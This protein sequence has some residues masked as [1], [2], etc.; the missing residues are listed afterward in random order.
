MEKG[1]KYVQMALEMGAEDAKV[2][3]IDDI[4][5]DPRPLLK[6]MYGCSDWGKRWTCPSSAKGL[7]P[8]E[9]ERI[10]K[11]YNWGILI[12]TDNARLAHEISYKVEMA[13]FF[14]DYPLAFSMIDCYLCET[15]AFPEPCRNPKKARPE[16]MGLGIDV[17]A[18][19][20]KQGLPIKVLTSRDEKKNYYAFVMIEFGFS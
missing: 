2:I 7:R 6:C 4:V 11:R 15:C 8:W 9:A 16:A 3:S 14:D 5:F 12:H 1:E 19:A 10:L 20:K 13:A 17:Y 18:T